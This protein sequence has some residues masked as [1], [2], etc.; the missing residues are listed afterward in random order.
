ML[1]TQDAER[2]VE[3]RVVLGRPEP[4]DDGDWSTPYEVHGPGPSDVW[5]GQAR[6]VDAM[7]SLVLGLAIL[8]HE[9]RA[10]IAR[11]GRL[12][13]EGD[14]DLGFSHSLPE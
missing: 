7:Q 14:P 9:L 6:G 11:F 4:R 3:I 13:W 1:E 8:P 10:R 2:P 5:R 12:T